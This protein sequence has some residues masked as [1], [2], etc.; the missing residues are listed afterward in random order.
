MWGHHQHGG[1][2]P[3]PLGEGSYPG[4]Y[5]GGQ[6]SHQTGGGG[7]SGEIGARKLFYIVSEMHGKVVD[8][9]SEDTSPGAKVVT[10]DK[11][12]PVRRSQL[13][14]LDSQKFIKSA[15]NDMTLSNKDS[16]QPLM[17]DLASKNMRTLWMFDGNKVTNLAGEVLDIKGEHKANGTELISYPYKG[18]SNQHWRQEFA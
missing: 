12:S 3:P 6:A 9:H 15:L 18:R 5:S 11:A 2:N 10:W 1:E 16:G 17:T 13:W 8:V 14:Y 7:A 4:V